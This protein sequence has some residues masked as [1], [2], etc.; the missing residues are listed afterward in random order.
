MQTPLPAGDFLGWIQT[1]GLAEPTGREGRPK[2]QSALGDG[3]VFKL[4]MASDVKGG[5]A[6]EITDRPLD[7]RGLDAGGPWDR[8]GVAMKKKECGCEAAS[9]EAVRSDTFK[10]HKENARP[11][12]NKSLS[13]DTP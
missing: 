4:A 8:T 12:K 10:T 7:P 13:P 2:V 9:S 3:R 1:Q 6:H 5:P 11:H